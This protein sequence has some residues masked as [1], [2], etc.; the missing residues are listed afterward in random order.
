MLGSSAKRRRCR[1]GQKLSLRPK[2]KRGRGPP[3]QR[4]LQGASK[5]ADHRFVRGQLA[6]DELQLP[7]SQVGKARVSKVDCRS[8]LAGRR[9]AARARA[10]ARTT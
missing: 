7:P 2:Q 1:Q 5:V 3:Q 9:G 10:D 4:C 6:L 8:R